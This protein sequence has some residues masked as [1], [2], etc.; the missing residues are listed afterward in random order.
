MDGTDSYDSPGIEKDGRMRLRPAALLSPV[1]LVMVACRGT[2][3]TTS[4][5]NI[6]TV[7]WVGTICSEPPMISVSIRKSR[8]SHQMIVESGEF[9]VNLVDTRLV[10]SADL[11]GVRSGRTMDKF[12]TCGLTSIQPVTLA[13]AP[14]IGESPL[15]LECKVKNRLELG[16]H[17][18]FLAEVVG[19]TVRPD[20]LADDGRL[21]LDR[22]D[23]VGYCHGEY[24][25]LGRCLGFFGYSIAG[26]EALDRRLKGR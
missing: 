21:T 7:A 11:C 6:I 3:E 10:R 13:Y 18:L 19:I 4:R 2:G 22:A 1:P 24:W 14:A 23:L 5:A 16:S 8:L 17:D 9:T 15:I 12:A 20:L 25:T 26:E